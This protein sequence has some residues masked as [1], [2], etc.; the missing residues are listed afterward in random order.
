MSCDHNCD[1]C[2]END[3]CQDKPVDEQDQN[4]NA[5]LAQVKHKL[6]VMSGKGGVGKSTVAANLAVTLSEQGYSVGLLDV[7]LHGPSIAGILGLIGLPLNAIGNK[8]LPFQYSENLQV[9]TVQGLLTDPDAALIWRGPLK[10]SVIKQ[11]LADTQWEP[12]DFLIIDCPPGTGDEPLTIVQTITDAQAIVVTTPQEVALADVRKSLNFCEQAHVAV[13]GI[14]ENMSGFVCPNC[15]T[16]HNIFKAGGGEKLAAD[17]KLTFLGKLPIDPQVVAGDDAGT[18]L[19]NL[20]PI[21]KAA[22]ASL[23]ANVLQALNK[24]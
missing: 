14:V 3:T 10:I 2:Q 17:R 9:M 12:L 18:P 15:Q 8:M 24:K 16:V 6:V 20:S 23:V 7:D 1:S 11:F 22:L 21:T 19:E 4:I 13:L 5:F